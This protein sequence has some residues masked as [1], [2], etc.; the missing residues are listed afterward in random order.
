MARGIIASALRSATS[1]GAARNAG[2][3]YNPK[4]GGN[5]S[6]R[7]YTAGANARMARGG[8]TG[9]AAHRAGL[10]AAGASGTP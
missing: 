6:Q 5:A 7:A 8:A 3:Y 10:Q 9:M 2:M 1:I 4:G